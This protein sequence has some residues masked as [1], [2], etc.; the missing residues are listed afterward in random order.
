MREQ[1]VNRDTGGGIE[2]HGGIMPPVMD[3]FRDPAVNDTYFAARQIGP[4]I[5]WNVVTIGE[6]SQRVGPIVVQPDIIVRRRAG[7]PARMEHCTSLAV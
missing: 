2:L 3:D 6:D 1:D 7:L 4:D 5:G